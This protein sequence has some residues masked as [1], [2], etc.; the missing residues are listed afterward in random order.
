VG[1][2]AAVYCNRKTISVEPS[3]IVVENRTYW[4][5]LAIS[6]EPSVKYKIEP[7]ETVVENRTYW[8]SSPRNN[9]YDARTQCF[10]Q[11]KN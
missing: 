6:V 8:N 4:S 3:R 11:R 9:K 7:T 1:P 10:E 2:T 5:S